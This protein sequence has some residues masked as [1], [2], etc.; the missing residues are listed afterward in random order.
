MVVVQSGAQNEL[1]LN[2]YS[3]VT[4]RAVPGQTG[5]PPSLG[6]VHGWQ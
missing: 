6:C 3:N 4:Q 1:A 5:M 2:W